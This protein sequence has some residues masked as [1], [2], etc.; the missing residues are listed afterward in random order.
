[1]NKILLTSALSLIML[2]SW[3]GD[4]NAKLIGES[5]D[6]KTVKMMWF[7]KK[8]D[9]NLTGF[10]IKRKTLKG[11]WVAINSEPIIPGISIDNNIQ[12]VENNTLELMRL[13]NKLNSLIVSGKIDAI[14][15]QTLVN[16]LI[17]N[18]DT[19][20]AMTQSFGKD[21]DMALLTGFGIV[22]RNVSND[23]VQYGL[24]Y[25]R[26]NHQEDASPS[27]ILNWKSGEIT[28]AN[29][30]VKVNTHTKGSNVELFWNVTFN[31]MDQ[32][33]AQGFNVY[34]KV[35]GSWIKINNSPIADFNNQRNAY[36]FVDVNNKDV[37]AEYAVSTAT[38]F[39]NEGYKNEVAV[40]TKQS[41]SEAV[42]ASSKSS[43]VEETVVKLN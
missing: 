4:I 8:W 33:H 38:M 7:L 41:V 2:S 3:A 19:L 40:R 10:N 34:R 21:Y 15:N 6:G 12:N 24:F 11:E 30:I 23:V 25:I 26:D 1:M 14:S 16:T 37:N 29:P 42:A 35:N 9:T 43:G 27:A 13:K 36:T 32:L 22:D 39:N 17:K 28:N 31:M 5:M 18:N 20:K